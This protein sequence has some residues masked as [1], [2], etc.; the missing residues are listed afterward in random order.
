M[1]TKNKPRKQQQDDGSLPQALREL[2]DAISALIDPKLGVVDHDSGPFNT[3]LDSLYEQL[4]DA[5]PGSKRDRTG[6]SRS[7]LPMWADALDLLRAID[8]QVA[9]WEPPF[10]M[11]P[12]DLTTMIPVTIL[13]LREIDDRKWRPQ[14]VDAINDMTTQLKAWATE[15]TKL[16]ADEH[17][18][19]LPDPCPACGK[20]TVYRNRDGEDI[21]T[22][23]LQITK[24]AGGF[25]CECQGCHTS[26][27]PSRFLFL[28]KVLGYELPEGVLE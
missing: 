9:K 14:D 7:Q 1:M 5:L 4:Q 10:P 15:I 6:V 28:G 11:Q 21:R 23:A 13:R 22:P 20:K 24:V 18:K 3:W 12:G 17:P 25:E 8:R 26:W 27:G 2:A 16:L 19:H